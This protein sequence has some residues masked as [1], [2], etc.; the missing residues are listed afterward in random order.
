[1]LYIKRVIT[2]LV[3]CGGLIVLLI[4]S[5]ALFMPKNNMS[6][7]GMEE[8]TANGVQGEKENTIDTL[9]VGDSETY[10]AITPMQIWKEKGYTSYVCGSS[11]QTLDYT[12]TLIKRVF[13]NQSP[14]LVVLETDAIYREISDDAAGLTEISNLFS[15]FRYHDRWKKLTANDLKTGAEYTWTEDNKGYVYSNTVQGCENSNYMLPTDTA[16]KIPSLNMIYIK[17][18]KNFCEANGARLVFLSIPSPV[19]WSYERHNG[20]IRMAE[21]LS[22]EY[23]DMN[24]LNDKIQI[25]WQQDTR[26]KGD[27]LN[28]FGA[29]KVTQYLADYLEQTG[30]FE[31]HREDVSYANWN[32]TLKRYEANVSG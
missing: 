5:S 10:S 6:E 27:H 29:K 7:F 31:D 2:F 26:D 20:I 19:N 8:M 24:L 25:D 13:K 28:Y 1:M 17:A 22:C 18:I 3:F 16:E 9:F 32:E 30:L 12:F 4:A 11:L 21:D 14:K 15:V 23:I